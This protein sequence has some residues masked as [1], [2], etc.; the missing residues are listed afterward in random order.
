MQRDAVAQPNPSAEYSA[1]FDEFVCQIDTSNSTSIS[2]G[3]KS[4][5]AAK[6]TSN[7]EYM[8]FGR[9]VELTEKIFG[10]LTATDMELVNRSQIVDGY[11]V[12]CLTKNS[13]PLRIAPAKLPCV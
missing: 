7:I 8:L 11:G 10:C 1:S 9:E 12:D 4:R 2:G 6:A 5:G 3:S 13:I